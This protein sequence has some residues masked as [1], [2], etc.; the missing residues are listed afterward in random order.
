MLAI[1]FACLFN[2]KS[3]KHIF[4]NINEANI[5]YSILLTTQEIEQHQ[6]ESDCKHTIGY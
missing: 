3:I 6:H 4:T 1:M 5:K 2:E